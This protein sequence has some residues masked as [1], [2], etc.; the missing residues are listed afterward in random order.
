MAVLDW[1]RVHRRPSRLSCP[2]RVIS[3]SSVEP[4]GALLFDSMNVPREGLLWDP[5]NCPL[6]G[7]SSTGQDASCLHN[8]RCTTT[9]GRH[10]VA[11]T[12]PAYWS[13]SGLR[14]ETP[15]A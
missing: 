11:L 5:L 2:A 10:S 12:L 8:G 14:P 9:G 15:A 3:R 4:H 1:P 13:S 6:R 7:S